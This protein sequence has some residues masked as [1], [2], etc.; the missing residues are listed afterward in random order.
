LRQT[1]VLAAHPSLGVDSPAELV[2]LA[3]QQPG[4]RYGTGSGLGSPQHIVV[5]WFAGF[6]RIKLQ[7]VPYRGGGRRSTIS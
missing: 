6:A 3:Q 5:Q 1:I 4:L 7:Q 2:S